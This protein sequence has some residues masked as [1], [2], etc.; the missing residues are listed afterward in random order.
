M[1][2]EYSYNFE[3]MLDELDRIANK[4]YPINLTWHTYK[5]TETTPPKLKKCTE[6]KGY[7]NVMGRV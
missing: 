4:E 7:K 1:R 5:E 3:T 2:N 6:L